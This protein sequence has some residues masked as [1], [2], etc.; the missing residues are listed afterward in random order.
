MLAALILTSAGRGEH[1]AGGTEESHLCVV[2]ARGWSEGLCTDYGV[3]KLN[4]NGNHWGTW[5]SRKSQAP[6]VDFLTKVGGTGGVE[7]W[8][9]SLELA[10]SE[11]MGG[12]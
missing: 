12:D 8:G 10:F 2:W 11:G 1:P 7:V 3:S 5:H 4:L 9:M 6:T